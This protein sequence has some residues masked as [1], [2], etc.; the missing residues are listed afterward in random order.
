LGFLG[1]VGLRWKKWCVDETFY[2]GAGL[3][4]LGE[5]GFGEY[6]WGDP[7]YRS[8]IYN[9]TDLSYLITF[10]RYATLKVGFNI[11]ITDKGV[12]TSQL[13]TLIASLPGKK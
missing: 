8:P 9:R 4:R 7:F 6:Y 3:Q 2:W 1:E 5:D 10:D 13:L 12:Q 11:H